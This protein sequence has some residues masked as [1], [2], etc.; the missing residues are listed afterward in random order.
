[1]RCLLILFTILSSFAA[2]GQQRVVETQQIVWMGYYQKAQLSERWALHTEL[3]GRWFLS[4][5][6]QHQWVVPR[7]HVHYLTKG[8]A[9]VGVGGSYFLQALPQN[10]EPV[11]LTRPEIRP[12]Q[13]LSLK[14]ALGKLKLEHRYRVEERFSRRVTN[15][16]L[17]EGWDFSWRFRYRAQL[18]IPL[19]QES[20][21]SPSLKVYD[22][23]LLNAGKPVQNNMF[24]QNRIGATLSLKVS[25]HVATELGYLHWFQQRPAGNTFFN[26]HIVR[27]TLVHSLSFYHKS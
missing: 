13:E 6:R 10:E 4:S 1:M 7:V 15:G 5:F 27:F 17:A 11:E 18:V 19:A 16:E 3:E 24:D 22:E 25:E 26:R 14:Q 2:S 20:R 8:G 23:I 21:L 9:D 12:H